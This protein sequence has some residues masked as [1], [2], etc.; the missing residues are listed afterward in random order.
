MLS[1]KPVSSVLAPRNASSRAGQKKDNFFHYKKKTLLY[2]RF[3]AV[4]DFSENS[5]DQL[6]ISLIKVDF[7][8]LE[9]SNRSESAKKRLLAGFGVLEKCRKIIGALNFEFFF[10]NPVGDGTLKGENRVVR[11]T[12]FFPGKK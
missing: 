2:Y 5:A 7:A 10:W 3:R 9:V 4:L 8:C 6:Q 11:K 1:I 12:Y